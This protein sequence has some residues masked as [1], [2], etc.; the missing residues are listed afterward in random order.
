[1]GCQTV[2]VDPPMPDEFAT[3][4]TRLLDELRAENITDPRVLDA[5][6]RVPRQEFVRPEDRQRAYRNE[7]LPISGGQTISQPYV[8]ALMT[9]LLELQGAERVLEVGTGSGYQGAVL[10]L[11]ARAVYSIEIDP[12]LAA[13]ARARLARLGYSNVHVR[14]GDGFYGW[15][16]A[17]PFDAI[18]ITAGAPRI[19]ERLVAQ[20]RP[21]GR[22]VMPLDENGEQVLIRVRKQDGGLLTT[23]RLAA[24][25]FVPMTSAVRTPAPTP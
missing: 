14:A 15:E 1:M 3:A 22:L 18:I 20:L 7:A 6:A 4:R 13:T 2:A 17:A 24:V 11:L 19:P 12:L 8:V 9:Q 21:G 5:I 25:A 23:E 16:D 10:A